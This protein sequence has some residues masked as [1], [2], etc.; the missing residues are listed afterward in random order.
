MGER[1]SMKAA[2]QTVRIRR[3]ETR[4]A[5]PV[6]DLVMRTLRISNT[7][8][9]AL[10]LIEGLM[11]EQQPERFIERAE[12]MHFYV[13]EACSRADPGT[14]EPGQNPVSVPSEIIGCAGIRKDA[15]DPE[16]TDIHSFYVKPECQK[17][18]IGRRIMETLEQDEYFLQTKRTLIH[19]SITAADFYRRLGYDFKDGL[20][21][22]DR[23]QLYTMVKYH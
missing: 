2:A 18:G 14:N 13:A 7:K 10:E 9:Y 21:A 4:D 23:Y 12:D 11:P 5:K 8:D 3:F 17:E 16:R 1:K 20:A 22:L 6:S 19:A 15:E